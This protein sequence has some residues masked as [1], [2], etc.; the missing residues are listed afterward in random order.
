M[1][2]AIISALLCFEYYRICVIKSVAVTVVLFFVL[3]TVLYE[4][5]DVFRKGQAWIKDSLRR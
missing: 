5:D 3:L 4:L 2:N 1:K